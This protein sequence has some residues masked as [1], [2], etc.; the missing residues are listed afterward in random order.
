MSHA[1]PMRG[2]GNRTPEGWVLLR[3]I[4]LDYLDGAEDQTL[5]LLRASSD[6]S[7]SSDELVER[8]TNWTQRYNVHPGRANVVRAFDLP[9]S[10]TVLEVGAGCGPVTRYLGERCAVVDAL[11]PVPERARVARERTRDLPNVEVFVGVLDD[12]PDV[13]A[14]DVVVVVGVLEWSSGGTADPE[15]YVAFLRK[16]RQVLRPGG[17][18]VLAIENKLGVKYLA[19]AAEDHTGRPFDGLEGYARPSRARTFSRAE[20]VDLFDAAG[21][22]A[23]TRVAFPDY[24]LTRTVLDPSRVPADAASLLHRIPT[25]PSPDWFGTSVEGADEELLW[26]SL[27]EAGLADETGNSFVVLARPHEQPRHGLWPDDRAGVYF[28]PD[29]RA[30][31]AVTTDVRVREDVVR[32]DRAPQPDHRTVEGVRVELA[33]AD[34]VP[35]RDFLDVFRDVDDPTSRALLQQWADL[36]ERSAVGEE[37]PLD[38]VPHNLV[39]GPDGLVRGIDDEWRARCDDTAELLGRG[40][41]TLGLRLAQ[42]RRY[43]EGAWAGCATLRDVISRIGAAVGLPA[44]GSWIDDAVERE[45]QLQSVVTLPPLG[46]TVA[47]TPELVR[48]TYADAMAATFP[49]D[50]ARGATARLEKDLAEL[51]AEYAH[52]FGDL[53]ELLP[54]Y[55]GA[56]ARVEALESEVRELRAGADEVERRAAATRALTSVLGSTWWRVSAPV[57]VVERAARPGAVASVHSLTAPT[58]EIERLVAD[59]RSGWAWRVTHPGRRA[60]R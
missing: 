27:C 7:A 55:H 29:R 51:R 4:E 36:V 22:T 47:S 20:L 54:E 34:Y 38:L 9:E 42:R 33:P 13:P 40:A 53:H 5:E 25:F 23:E 16:I 19:G 8:A 60:G 2:Q 59:V 14:Y 50:A 39:V 46:E 24:K 11:E 41:L 44:D 32:F 15:P 3:D 30:A 48:R 49:S 17:A 21:L 26:R 56:L 1:T 37:A 18:V 52:V 45:V 35:G 6:V 10:A 28:T 43:D 12:V 31:F 57:R 58:A